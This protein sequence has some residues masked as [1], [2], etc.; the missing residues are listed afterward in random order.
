VTTAGR[1]RNDQI[2]T[3]ATIG[4]S[5]LRSTDAAVGTVDSIQIV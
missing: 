1:R 2:W 3:D 5:G 4:R